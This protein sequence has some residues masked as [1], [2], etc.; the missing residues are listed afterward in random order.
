MLRSFF[1]ALFVNKAAPISV[2][3]ATGPQLCKNENVTFRGWL[4]GSTDYKTLILFDRALNAKQ[5]SIK[6]GWLI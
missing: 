2:I 6:E 3:L 5:K 1:P 4:N